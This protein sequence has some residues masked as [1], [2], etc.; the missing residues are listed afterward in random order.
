M[1]RLLTPTDA[2]AMINE[3][4]RQATG[5]KTLTAYDTSSFVSVGEKILANRCHGPHF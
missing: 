4:A 1:G 3:I 5:Q 2:Y